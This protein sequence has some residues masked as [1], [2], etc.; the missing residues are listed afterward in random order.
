[1][2]TWKSICFLS[3]LLSTG[4]INSLQAQWQLM[5]YTASS[6]VWGIK[7]HNDNLYAFGIRG[8]GVQMS[9]DDGMTWSS[10]NNGLDTFLLVCL[11]PDDQ[12]LWAGNQLTG[13]YLSEDHGNTWVHTN[14]TDVDCGYD[15]V[16]KGNTMVAGTGNRL[17]GTNNNGNSWFSMDPNL[18]LINDGQVTSVETIGNSIFVAHGDIER[19]D[20]N[21]NSWTP[22]FPFFLGN[23]YTPLFTD[24][25]NLYIGTEFGLYRSP[26]MGA[27]WETLHT[28]STLDLIVLGDTLISVGGDI[29]LS[30]DNGNN[31]INVTQYLT[32]ETIVSV[33]VHNGFVFVG[34]MGRE[35][36]R[37][38][39]TQLL[40]IASNNTIQNSRQIHVSP[41]P[42]TQMVNIQCSSTDEILRE[43]EIHDLSGQKIESGSL[44]NS[45]NTLF[46]GNLNPGLYLIQVKSNRN[47]YTQKLGILR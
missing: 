8:S 1:M 5:P 42:A 24:A 22:I 45:G 12:R 37:H 2:K 15:I 26:D 13:F 16:R 28:N 21:G 36:Y 43:Y 31:W 30:V 25:G 19:S 23:S 27:T 9:A 11:Y 32:D 41:N 40:A 14:S 33:N 18:I 17:W 6:R 47:S 7:I 4:L 38:G 46:I 10:M 35:I 34:T 44:S 29:L 39:L 20:N 3:I